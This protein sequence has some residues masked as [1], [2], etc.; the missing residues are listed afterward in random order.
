MRRWKFTSKTIKDDRD[1]LNFDKKLRAAVS[2]DPTEREETP[3][4]GGSVVGDLKDE[5]DLDVDRVPAI[6]GLTGYP[7]RRFEDIAT[8]RNHFIN[9][10]DRMDLETVMDGDRSLGRHRY[11]NLACIR[12]GP[13]T[14]D[15]I[16]TARAPPRSKKWG[17]PFSGD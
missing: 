1:C 17:D 12:S 15:E 16:E 7:F 10:V 9:R 4:P 3:N 13:L 11:L 2:I 5:G 14:A 6:Q 8:L